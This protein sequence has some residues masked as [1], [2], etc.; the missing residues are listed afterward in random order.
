MTRNAPKAVAHA[1]PHAA[2]WLIR[3]PP[4]SMA[5]AQAAARQPAA[6][7]HVPPGS[8]SPC[9]A[10]CCLRH[11]LPMP[12]KATGTTQP[13]PCACNIPRTPA[14][15]PTLMHC[16]RC[17]SLSG[18]RLLQL[19]TLST[20]RSCWKARL[21]GGCWRM[22]TGTPICTPACSV[23]PAGGQGWGVL[24][25]LGCLG[26]QEWVFWGRTGRGGSSATGRLWHPLGHCRCGQQGAE[27][28]PGC[29]PV[30]AGGAALA[31]RLSSRRRPPT[32]AGA[33]AAGAV[34]H[35]GA[36]VPGC[37]IVQPAG[38]TQATRDPLLLLVAETLT[39]IEMVLG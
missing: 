28:V 12:C 4:P 16:P 35:R 25:V 11:L 8:A 24:G 3:P 10:R 15:P 38:G 13:A 21:V 34:R 29:M 5:L 27:G 17:C 26:G 22:I 23:R 20:V 19:T 7:R 39:T 36:Y 14:P 9:G 18:A 31:G 2:P 1:P 30:R 32:A 33:G 6:R 37:V